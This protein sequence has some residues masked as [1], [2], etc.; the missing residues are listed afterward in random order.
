MRQMAYTMSDISCIN[1]ELSLVL[2]AL[3]DRV[4]IISESGVVLDVFGAADTNVSYASGELV[5]IS[6]DSLISDEFAKECKELIRKALCTLETQHHIY[7]LYPKDFSQLPDVV[8]PINTQWYEGR[9]HPL[10]ESYKGERAVVW[11]A[12]NITNSHNL[13]EKLF[14]LSRLDDLTQVLNR[15]AFNEM[16]KQCFATRKRYGLCTSVM[17][18]DIDSFKSINDTYGHLFGDKVITEVAA[19]I[20]DESRDTDNVAR[21]GGD[22][23]SVILNHTSINDAVYFAERVCK[24]IENHAFTF[25]NNQIQITVSI[26]V[27]QILGSDKYQ[28][29]VLQRADDAL[30]KAKLKGRNQVATKIG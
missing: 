17:I 6:L 20:L 19:L 24:T 22:E 12:R 25:L 4:F 23:F 18:M 10:Q 9:I 21:L 7:K 2:S 30:Y 13:Q 14:E 29:D 11:I 1:N 8:V 5:G 26:G 16:L 3:P 15:R 28:A 27:S